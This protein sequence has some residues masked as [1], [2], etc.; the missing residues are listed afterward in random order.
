MKVSTR[1]EY[2]MRA[3]VSL[4]REYGNGPVALTSVAH[5]SSVP[6]AY[7]EQLMGVMRRA[8]LIVSTRGA[9]GGYELARAP[10]DI[11]VGDIYRVLEGPVAPMEC[12]SEVESE[13]ICPLLDGCATRVVWLKVRDNIVE[14]LDSTTLADLIGGSRPRRPRTAKA[15][16]L[17]TAHP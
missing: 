16:P 12:V 4:A 11:R 13:D 5:D 17:E 7:L 15:I 9:H 1:G 3:M 6:A 14:A 2:G 10:E 8:G